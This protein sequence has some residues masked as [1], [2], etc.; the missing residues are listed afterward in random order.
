M[1]NFTKS[2]KK[3]YKFD[4]DTITVTMNRLKRKA[5]L[6]L[7]PYMKYDDDGEL[8]MTFQDRMQF[9]DI[10]ADVLR[11]HVTSFTGMCIENVDVNIA[12]EETMDSIFEESYFMSLLSDMLSDLMSESFMSGTDEGKSDAPSEDTL[13]DSETKQVEKSAEQVTENG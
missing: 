6:K 12:D 10:G 11:K 7:T 1:S 4:G 13:E 8:R 2:I 9:M 3:E 5:A